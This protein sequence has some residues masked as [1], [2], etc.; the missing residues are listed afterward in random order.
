MISV[1]CHN[2]YDIG[3]CMY[4]TRLVT[5][6]D[7]SKLKTAIRNQVGSRCFGVVTRVS[8]IRRVEMSIPSKD[9][10]M[11]AVYDD[12]PTSVRRPVTCVHVHAMHVVEKLSPISG[13][14]TN[15]LPRRTA[16]LSCE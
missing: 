4:T 16:R 12:R 14:P 3:V 13:S 5:P 2:Y 11:S 15:R 10:H 8:Q 9:A 7:H 6:D 1:A